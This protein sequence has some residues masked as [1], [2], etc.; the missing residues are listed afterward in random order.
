MGKRGRGKKKKG[1]I[2]VAAMNAVILSNP[3]LRRKKKPKIS[4]LPSLYYE[5]GRKKE[6]G[7][8]PTSFPT[9]KEGGDLGV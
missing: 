6:S 1:K 7:V 2:G 3:V 4:C 5:G 9:S 8:D